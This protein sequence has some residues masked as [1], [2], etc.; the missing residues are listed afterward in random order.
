MAIQWPL[1]LFSLLAGSGGAVMA[2]VAISEF[3]GVFEKTNR[4]ASCIALVLMA[5]GGF[6]SMVHLA[7][8]QNVMA[9]VANLGSFSGISL[10]L[11]FLAAT[12]GTTLVYGVM[13][14]RNMAG[15]T[16][17]RAVA[18]VAGLLGVILG[19]VCGHGYVIEAQ[20]GWDTET[21]AFAYLGTS[22]ALGAFIYLV[23]GAMRHE[24]TEEKQA[25]SMVAIG[26]SAICLI[27]VIAYLLA[28]DVDSVSEV[29]L[30]AG[31]ALLGSVGALVFSVLMKKRFQG[32]LPW[33]GLVCA[34]A[35]GLGLR[36]MMWQLGTGFIDFFGLAAASPVIL[37]L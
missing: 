18:G 21:L 10:E 22:L 7:H 14:F 2:C 1:V 8:P 12:G 23:V 6:A 25:F 32:V 36:I 19:Y 3:R 37:N 34:L 26:A 20:P 11:I 17:R 4:S 28:C 27:T 9:A 30:A 24:P 33:A 16:L 35:A 29:A 13:V 5:V 15:V 31:V